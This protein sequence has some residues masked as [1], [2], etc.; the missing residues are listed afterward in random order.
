[1]II[2]VIAYLLKA[3]PITFMMII[4]PFPNRDYWYNKLDKITDRLLENI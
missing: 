3:I 4:I 1:M 2:R